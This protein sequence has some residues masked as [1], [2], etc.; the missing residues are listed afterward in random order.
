VLH[1]SGRDTVAIRVAAV[2]LSTVGDPIRAELAQ[3]RRASPNVIT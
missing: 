3:N 2:R 1:A